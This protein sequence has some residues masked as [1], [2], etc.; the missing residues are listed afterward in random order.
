MKRFRGAAR[1]SRIGS[2]RESAHLPVSFRAANL[3]KNLS[4]TS[5][6]GDANYNQGPDVMQAIQ[7]MRQKAKEAGHLQTTP[8]QTVTEEGD[9]IDI[10][11]TNPDVVYVP[12]YDPQLIYGYPVGLWPG[13]YPWWV[14][15]VRIYLSASGLAS[16]HS[17]DSAG[18][19]MD[20]ALIGVEATCAMEAAVMAFIVTHSTI[21]MHTSTAITEASHLMAAAIAARGNLLPPD[22]GP[23]VPEVL[24]VIAVPPVNVP[25]LLEEFGAAANPADFPHG[26]GRALVEERAAVVAECTAAVDMEAAADADPHWAHQTTASKSQKGTDHDIGKSDSRRHFLGMRDVLMATA[27]AA[28][29]FSATLAAGQSNT[30]KPA[31]ATPTSAT[32]CIWPRR[33]P[34]NKH[35]LPQKTPARRWSQP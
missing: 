2:Q 16:A 31:A 26:A 35:F 8:Q 14:L 20:G 1:I 15:A 23:R 29:G 28:L 34:D 27:I 13:F 25:A 22:V 9:D 12:E 11:P 21:A 24:P 6:L 32:R 30:Q 10:A 33:K 19:G 4:W 5:E 3:N 18:D 17:L 7:V